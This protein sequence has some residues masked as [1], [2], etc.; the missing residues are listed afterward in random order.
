MEWGFDGVLLST[1]VSRAID[2]V[3][4]A[5]AFSQAVQAGRAA[6]LAGPTVARET[7]TAS[8]P[9]IGRPFTFQGIDL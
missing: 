1:A 4:M 7:A 5:G 9:E 8:T 6:F 2:P 3:R